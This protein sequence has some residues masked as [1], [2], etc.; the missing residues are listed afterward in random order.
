M[1]RKKKEAGQKTEGTASRRKRHQE[2]AALS[3][4]GQNFIEED[5]NK[6]LIKRFCAEM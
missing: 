3:A 2:A 1:L 5:I 6:T 4:R